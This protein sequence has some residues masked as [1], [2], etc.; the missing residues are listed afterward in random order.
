M[1]AFPAVYIQPRLN[2]LG[3]PALSLLAAKRETSTKVMLVTLL[4]FALSPSQ[5]PPGTV[6]QNSL[7]DSIFSGDI[8]QNAGNISVEAPKPANYAP[9]TFI[10]AYFYALH[11]MCIYLV[12]RASSPNQFNIKV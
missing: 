11:R 8:D 12:Y 9:S 7:I 10:A 3:S 6:S 5:S 1:R 2:P 4:S